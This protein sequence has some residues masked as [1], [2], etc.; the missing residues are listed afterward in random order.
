M[1][2]RAIYYA[3]ILLVCAISAVAGISANYTGSVT[4]PAPQNV[5]LLGV[6]EGIDVRWDIPSGSD[7]VVN[8]QIAYQ[9]MQRQR[10][11]SWAFMWTQ[12]K[13]STHLIRHLAGGYEY[14]VYVRSCSETQC[15]SAWA[16][17]GTVWTEKPRS[18]TYNPVPTATP[19]PLP[20]LTPTPTPT[21][22]ATPT[23]T[24]T[25]V[26]VHA[27]WPT[28][29][30]TPT[31]VYTPTRVP[32]QSYRYE[33][34]PEIT[35]VRKYNKAL[36]VEW[37]PGWGHWYARPLPRFMIAWRDLSLPNTTANWS[38]DTV[39]ATG[40]GNHLWIDGL[41]N[42]RTYAV[43]VK[44]YTSE[45]SSDWAVASAKP[46]AI[47]TPTP[48]R[49]AMSTCFG[50]DR[51]VK[52][53]ASLD[54]YSPAGRR[55]FEGKDKLFGGAGSGRVDTA[56]VRTTFLNPRAKDGISSWQY[57]YKFREWGDSKYGLYL[58]IKNDRTW[59]F[60]LR[61]ETNRV[62]D[63]GTVAVEDFDDRVSDPVS[64]KW[65]N[66]NLLCY[67]PSQ[68]RNTL[69]LSIDGKFN[70]RFSVNGVEIA[71]AIDAEEQALLNS[72]LYERLAAT[73]WNPNGLWFKWVGAYGCGGLV[74]NCYDHHYGLQMG[75]TDFVEGRFEP[76][77][78]KGT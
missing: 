8:Y 63:S 21:P 74:K 4:L 65:V 78:E 68:Y 71:L 40:T 30:P 16:Y 23:F 58:L 43:Y 2:R 42:E 51:G 18:V 53:H 44:A 25:P 70:F 28:S 69:G 55:V 62:L 13:V 52:Y 19:T 77:H 75:S 59:T 48:Q 3:L 46:S 76:L 35:T 15:I 38:I 32:E 22:T 72:T 17:G 1:S 39:A 64:K 56:E 47:P 29:T 10:A 50:G 11:D 57:G 5:T 12:G 20:T 7:E 73:E 31:P 60:E 67:W 61:G 41:T 14:R 6:T 24:P 27:I 66:G 36:Q 54:P 37:K 9:A 26:V 34:K 49:Q 45:E 33:W